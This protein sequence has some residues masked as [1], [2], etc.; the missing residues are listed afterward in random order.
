MLKILIASHGRAFG[1]R[2]LDCCGFGE[3]ALSESLRGNEAVI[4]KTKPQHGNARA[5]R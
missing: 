1:L 2:L 4:E 5:L 3:M